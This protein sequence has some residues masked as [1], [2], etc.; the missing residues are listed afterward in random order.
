MVTTYLNNEQTYNKYNK[1][2]VQKID[3]YRDQ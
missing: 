1:A 3:Q 2:I